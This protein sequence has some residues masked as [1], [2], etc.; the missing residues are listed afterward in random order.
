VRLGHY[1]FERCKHPS[2]PIELSSKCLL[3]YIGLVLL[4]FSIL[5]ALRIG[6]VFILVKRVLHIALIT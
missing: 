1:A 6:K 5:L 3:D 2:A 4:D